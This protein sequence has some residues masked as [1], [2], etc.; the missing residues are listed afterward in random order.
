MWSCLTLMTLD[1]VDLPMRKL[2]D[3]DCWESPVARYL[4]VIASFSFEDIGAHPLTFPPF[5]LCLGSSFVWSSECRWSKRSGVILKNLQPTNRQKKYNILGKWYN[6][7]QK[8]IDINDM[9]YV[10]MENWSRYR[11][12]RNLHMV[13]RCTDKVLHESKIII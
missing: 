9:I 11:A 6:R 12:K 1:T 7:K 5:S 10:V 4:K 13:K 3:S 8:I 2:N